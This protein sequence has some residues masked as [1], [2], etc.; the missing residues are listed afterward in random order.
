MG[1]MGRFW[2]PCETANSVPLD[3]HALIWT[4]FS[5]KLRPDEHIFFTGV[6]GQLAV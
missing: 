1:D 6:S 3:A 5:E 2:V 4:H